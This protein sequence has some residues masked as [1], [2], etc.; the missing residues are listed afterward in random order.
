MFKIFS[1]IP[2]ILKHGKFL[3]LVVDTVNYFYS[4]AISRGLYNADSKKPE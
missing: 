4:E 1:V 2:K 3:L